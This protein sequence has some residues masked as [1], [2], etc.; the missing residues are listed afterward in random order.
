[1]KMNIIDSVKNTA[2]YSSGTYCIRI[3]GK[4]SGDKHSEADGAGR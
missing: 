2:F 1:M 3:S 4:G